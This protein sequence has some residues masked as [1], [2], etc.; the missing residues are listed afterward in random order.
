MFYV[1]VAFFAIS[2]ALLGPWLERNGP[3]KGLLLGSCLF[4]FGNL[5]TALGVYVKQLAVIYIGYGVFGAMGLGISYIS[6]VSPLQKWFPEIRGVA[7]GLAVCGFG[8]GS[9]FSPFTQ[10][11]SSF[12]FQ[13]LKRFHAVFDEVEN[14]KSV[15]QFVANIPYF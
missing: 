7:A 6:P 4:F 1:A 10:K 14:N 9:V 15:L 8:A 5:L 12:L 3:L 2:A 13:K 11:G